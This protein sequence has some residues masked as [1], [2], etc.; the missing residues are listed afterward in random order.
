M[1]QIP[2]VLFF[3]QST[4]I[5]SELKINLA[6][7]EIKTV[8]ALAVNTFVPKALNMLHTKSFVIYR[9]LFMLSV[10]GTSHYVGQ[11]LLRYCQFRRLMAS[12]YSNVMIE[13]ITAITAMHQFLL[14]TYSTSVIERIIVI[15]TDDREMQKHNIII[16]VSIFLSNI[17]H[18]CSE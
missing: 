6:T 12:F 2:F 16:N 13:M 7:K 5:L 17:Y 3:F 4:K 9:R 15:I 11:K 10:P 18:C 1:L 14:L 8:G